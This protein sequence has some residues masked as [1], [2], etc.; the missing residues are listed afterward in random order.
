MSD[1]SSHD[2]LDAL[3]AAP[4]HH[5]LLMEN[6]RVRVLETVIAAGDRTPIH[7]HRWPGVLHILSWSHFIR[8]DDQGKIMLGSQKVE[9]LL[10]P[11]SIQWGAA[12]PT[13]SLENIGETELRLIAMELKD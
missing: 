5:R 9:A 3:I 7:T 4:N 12:L 10:N 8:F 6:E 11:P 1:I 2:P 13:H